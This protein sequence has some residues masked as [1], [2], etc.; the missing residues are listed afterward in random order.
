[1]STF[2]DENRRTVTG[3]KLAGLLAWLASIR[4]ILAPMLV[5]GTVISG[6]VLLTPA[7]PRPASAII[8]LDDALHPRDLAGGAMVLRD[9]GGTLTVEE[10]AAMDAA[11]FEPLAR[12]LAAGFDAAAYWLRFTVEAA[13]QVQGGWW[14]EVGMPYLDHVDLFVPG[15]QGFERVPSGDRLPLSSRAMRHRN[16]MF[17]LPVGDGL[18]TFHLR[19]QSA[20]TIA[21]KAR[22]WSLHAF[23]GQ[24]GIDSLLLGAL[25]GS[26]LVIVLFAGVQWALLRDRTYALFGLYVA[27]LGAMHASVN[28]LVPFLGLGELPAVTDAFTGVSVCLAAT[29][30]SLFIIPILDMPRSYPRTAWCYRIYAVAC[31][32]MAAS[33][34]FGG[35]AAGVG[36]AI[37]VTGLVANLA[38]C[39][40]A[41]AAGRRGDA[42]AR[43]YLLAWSFYLTGIALITLRNLGTIPTSPMIDWAPQVGVVVQVL[44]LAIGL[45]ERVRSIDTERQDAQ[46]ALLDA[47][48]R[49]EGELAIRVAERTQALTEAYQAME[50]ALA[51]ERDARTEQRNFFAMVSHEFRTPL[52]V[53]GTSAQLVAMSP[54]T[55]QDAAE[56]DKIQRAVRRMTALMDSCLTEEWLETAIAQVRD[57][58]FA[59]DQHIPLWVEEKRRIS[60]RR[61]LYEATLSAPASYRGDPVLI[62]IAVSNLVDNA[63]KYSDRNTPVRVRLDSH[64][65]GVRI[66]VINQGPGIAPEMRERI[67]EKFFR[68]PGLERISGAG[69]GL[70]MVRRI[71]ELHGGRIELRSTPGGETAFT[72]A[73][74]SR[75]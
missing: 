16:F 12:D 19:V 8:Q 34:P 72:L 15:P 67:F 13:V 38:S 60:D 75:A 30:G 5:T 41:V 32:A 14:L 61:I 6:T 47:A 17:A 3:P 20:S 37:H 1:M 62:G 29:A 27:A 22:I 21:V 33:V 69:L 55:Q 52:A 35:Y 64:E 24:A 39:V 71:L 43:H 7:P 59:L 9:P 73:L 49:S 63:V 40:V 48:R 53:I 65:G 58:P 28:G 23:S 51:S 45:A 26:V 18:T 11:A 42:M 31:L 74:P 50:E 57:Q 25:S 4:W 36:P 46:A 54:L 68:A 66:S 10:V 2:F 56:I 70:Y 44:L